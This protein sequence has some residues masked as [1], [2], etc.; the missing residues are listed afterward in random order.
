MLVMTSPA[1][2]IHTQLQVRGQQCGREAR[3]PARSS[4]HAVYWEARTPTECSMLDRFQSSRSSVLMS[5]TSQENGL[6]K[7]SNK[8]L[9]EAVDHVRDILVIDVTIP[10]GAGNSKREQL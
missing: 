5:N 6:A 10:F 7:R 4:G 3:N 8:S 2:F 9:L 1:N